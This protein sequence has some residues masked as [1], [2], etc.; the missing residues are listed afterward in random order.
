MTGN[1]KRF[2]KSKGY[3]SIDRSMLQD[4]DNLSLEAIGL[5]SNLVSYPDNWV[6][7]KT[8]LYKR[9]AKSKRNKVESAWNNLVEEKYIVQ[10]RK[11]NGKKYDYLYYFATERFS[12]E[13]IREISKQ[14]QADIW[15]GKISKNTI[16]KVKEEQ[17][18]PENIWNADFQQSNLDSSKPTD[19]KYTINKLTNNKLDTKDTKIKD[20]IFKQAYINNKEKIPKRLAETLS[21][22]TNSNIE[23]DQHYRII[24]IAKSLIE[25]NLG[26]PLFFE[27][28]DILLNVVIQ[29]YANA[30]RKIEKGYP[31]NKNIQNKDG[32]IFTSVMN[33]L[34][35][36][37]KERFPYKNLET[38]HAMQTAFISFLNN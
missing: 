34:Q 26:F 9:F 35:N 19:N 31:E 21:A 11:R 22:L 15:D 28:D 10:L 20:E 12:D 38:K 14:E 16:E 37:I 5:L 33:Q 1:V 36:L 27:E 7:H 23:L 32:Y 25:K 2:T 13:E 4:E 3:E 8:E 18:F 17:S 29:G 6:L 24:L 30:V